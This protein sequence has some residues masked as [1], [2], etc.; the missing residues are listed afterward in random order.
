MSEIINEVPSTTPDFTTEAA[1]Q[2]AELFPEVVADGKINLDTLKTILDIDVEDGRER[3]GLMWPGKREA[4]RAAQTPTTATLMPDKENSVNW[5]TTQNVFIEGDNLEVLKIL[6]KHYY[7]QIKMIYIDPPYNTGNDFVYSDDYADPIGSYLQLTGQSDE[8][9]KL[10]TN[11]ESAGR[12][13]SNWLNMMYPRIKLAKNL[14]REDG[15]MFISIDEHE[16]HNLTLACQEIFGADNV[17]GAMP[18]IMNLKGNQDKFGFADTHEFV[19]VC[20]RNRAEFKFGKLPIDD[21]TV[22][23]EWQIDEHG[24]YKQADNLRATG[25]NAPRS[26]RP[27]LWYPI[28][29]DPETRNIYV[30]SDD[31]PLQAGH[32]AVYPV[33]PKGEELSWYW[34]KSTFEE[35]KH[36]LIIKCTSNGWQFYRKQRPEL[37]QAPSSKPKSVLFSPKYSTSTSTTFLAEFLD[38]K[39]FDTPKPLPFIKDLFHIAG[40]K[41]GIVLDFFAG[42]G[43]TAHAAMSLN[44]EDGGTRRSI[45]VQLP[46][47]TAP[48]SLARERG[49]ETISS[50]TRERVYRASSEISA[51]FSHASGSDG[52]DVGLR[53]YKLVDTNFTKW[54][55]DSGLSRKELTDLF[56]GMSESAD[57]DAQPEALLVEVL[58]KLGLSLTED[59]KAV[60][61]SGLDVFSVD[62]GLMLAYLNEHV[63]PTLE[64]L[65]ALVAQQPSKL[66]VLED[67]FKGNDELKTNLVQECRT[68]GVDLWTA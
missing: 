67:A 10:S 29:V 18:V 22:E 45:L 44:E 47:P 62:G 46:E 41:E 20:L 5:N 43:T 66:V 33:N 63:P 50:I 35:N 52:V 64:Q 28:F 1:S 4:I 36:N 25:I 3:F 55:A 42:S 37:G 34:K 11:S 59:V 14:M 12:F 9:G 30:T 21:E 68:H 32:E 38:G 39:V 19:L 58:L 51:R 16:V 7:G 15:I 49:Y 54:R 57:D 65:R 2:L 8:E 61:I 27:N 31:M 40:M 17:V 53:A 56:A 48:G 60:Q 6:Q 23:K 26:K 13:H 24:L